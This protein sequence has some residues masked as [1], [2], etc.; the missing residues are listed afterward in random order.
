MT[1]SIKEL[2]G[3]RKSLSAAWGLHRSPRPSVVTPDV[4][5]QAIARPVQCPSL[6]D[7]PQKPLQPFGAAAI[8]ELVRLRGHGWALPEMSGLWW[9]QQVLRN[10]PPTLRPLQLSP[11]L[12]LGDCIFTIITELQLFEIY[13]STPLPYASCV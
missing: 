13:S 6:G 10:L 2:D 11:L 9:G 7:R 12:G 5:A 8:S 4:L 1:F 3:S